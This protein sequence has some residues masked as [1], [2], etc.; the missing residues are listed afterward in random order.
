MSQPSMAANPESGMGYTPHCNHP[1]RLL[2]YKLM[3]RHAIRDLPKL[4]R[5]DVHPQPSFFHIEF[6]SP[7]S[8]AQAKV[9]TLRETPVT[10]WN[11]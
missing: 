1:S 4:S 3:N 9:T 5:S 10:R 11:E 6:L 2:S 8:K 7:R